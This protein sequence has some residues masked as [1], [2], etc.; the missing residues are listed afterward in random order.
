MGHRDGA[1]RRRTRLM[2]NGMNGLF[3]DCKERSCLA[4]I[5]LY[6]SNG[7]T[8]RCDSQITFKLQPDGRY[9][10]DMFAVFVD[11][12]DEERNVP[13]AGGEKSAFGRRRPLCLIEC[14][15]PSNKVQASQKD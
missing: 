4:S 3:L 1:R 8:M 6:Q 5:N 11:W 2:P 15:K 7:N 10:G 12:T 14:R 13:D 9:N